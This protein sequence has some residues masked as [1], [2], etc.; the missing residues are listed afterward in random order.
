MQPKENRYLGNPNLPTQNATFEW[1]PEMIAELQKCKD[2]IFHFAETHFHVVSLDEG[3]IKIPLYKPQKRILKSLISNRFVVLLSSRQA[4]KTTLMCIYAL[5]SVCFNPDQRVLIVANKEDTAIK[6]FRRVRMAYELLPNYL[7]PGVKEWGVTGMILANDSSI[8]ISTTT[9]D[10]AR[11]DTVNT[12]IIDEM[13]SI[14]YNLAEEFWKSTIP[15]ISSSKKAK[16]FA[17]STPRGTGNKF[18]D[19]YSGAERNENGWKSERI[20]WWEIPGRNK[21]WKDEMTSSLGS[22][23]A[24]DQEFGNV[25]I[26]QGQ[27]AIDSDL[28]E[29]FKANNKKPFII[30]EDGSYKIF[31]EPVIDHVYTI[32]V[33]ISEGISQ[34]ASVCQIFDITDLTDIEQVAIYHNNKLDPH[35]FAAKVFMIANQWGRPPLLIERNNCGGQVI[36]ALIHNYQYT[37]LV[38]YIPDKK[39]I[40]DTR[41]G[42]YSHVN[43]RYK[44]IM[45]MRYWINTLRS[46]KI[47]DIATI[48]ELE[49]FVRHPNGTWRKKQG[50]ANFDDRVLAM[51]WGL[52]VLETDIAEKYLEIASFDEKGKPSKVLSLEL[53]SK[54]HFKLDKTTEVSTNKPMTVWLGIGP[55]TSV[56]DSNPDQDDLM[57]QGWTFM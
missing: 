43:S 38:D 2:D 44:G 5:W 25:F 54:E 57:S 35:S 41:R 28:I 22:K 49:T 37:N 51:V 15:V 34:A 31:K 55:S 19:V 21:K 12:L 8:G 52:F 9:S 50:E 6:I 33:D 4:G 17:V 36:D 29:E 40:F 30:L 24:F 3:K 27:S 39:K 23:E 26:E 47:N 56:I 20:D 11:G 45:N 1:K 46:V 32:G 16:I 10:A 42:I 13:A 14:P 48:Q 18:Y 7:K 53:A